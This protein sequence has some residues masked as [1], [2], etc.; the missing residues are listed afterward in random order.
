MELTQYI[1]LVRKWAWLIILAAFVAAGIAFVINIR[2]PPVYQAQTTLSIG[3]F[4]EAPNPNSADIR[5][6][7]D[8]AQTYAQLVTTFDVLQEAI[9]DLDLPITTDQLRSRITTRIITGTSL[10]VVTVTYDDPV[11]AADITNALAQ[12]LIAQSPTNL[13]ADQQTQVAFLNTQIQDLTIQV[14]GSRVQL[15]ELDTALSSAP[16]EA[17]TERLT[18]QRNATIDQINEAQATIA[19]FTG[20]IAS[21]QERTNALDI[22][23][24]ARIPTLQSGSRIETTVLLGGLV[25]AMLAF[26]VALLLEYLDDTVRTTEDAT[27]LLATP[28]LGAIVRFG[29]ATDKYSD[30]LLTNFP[31]MSPVAEGY[32]TARTNLLFTNKQDK[33]NVFI[34]TS[35]NPQEGKTIT[36]ANI[37]VTMAQAGF[38][39]LLIDADLRRP[40]LHEVFHLDNSVGL[41]TLL[42]SEPDSVKGDTVATGNYAGLP[43]SFQQCVQYTGIPKLHVLTSGFIP[44]NP[45][46][47]LGSTVMTHWMNVFRASPAIDIILIDTPPCLAAAD[48]PV[49]AATTE[50]EVVLV[51]DCGKTRRGAATRAKEQFTKLGIELKGVVVNRVNP[52]DEDYGYYY[53][54]YYSPQNTAADKGRRGLK[55]RN[56]N[57]Q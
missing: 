20:T 45:A 32:R 5:T 14:Q 4:I 34:I 21:L 7:I 39:V 55:L 6:G 8:L 30:M 43:L 1:R 27:Q 10:L 50:A 12:Q 38:Q 15:G 41:T 19:Q 56:R 24:Q 37:A 17:E 25:G 35:A 46:E 3:R 9:D 11:L 54:Y 31:S 23:E 28:V 48:S 29:K 2:R 51:V 13:T 52:R 18:N 22:V 26:G 42:F 36:T 49:L 40:K 57:T 47:V 53:G 16:T 33:K 44:S